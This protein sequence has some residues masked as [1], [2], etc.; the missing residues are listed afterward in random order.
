MNNG[1]ISFSTYNHQNKYRCGITQ[2]MHKL[3]H[4]TEKIAENPTEKKNIIRFFFDNK[5]K[6]FQTY[7]FLP[8]EKLFGFCYFTKYFYY[9]NQKSQTYVYV[10]SVHIRGTDE[11]L[12]KQS[13]L[14]I[15]WNPQS[16]FVVSF[17]AH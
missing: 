11:N 3:V 16:A 10:N 1:E 2:R 13:F 7:I 8:V 15:L 14:W 5:W 9:K 12:N 4:F 6:F 17:A